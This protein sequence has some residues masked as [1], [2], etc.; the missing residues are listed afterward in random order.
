M[1]I[2][3][4]ADDHVG[5]SM[6]RIMATDSHDV[7][8]PYPDFE[9]LAQ[10]RN[11]RLWMV[12]NLKGLKSKVY[13]RLADK[14]KRCDDISHCGSGMC[15]MCMRRVRLKWVNDGMAH[16]EREWT[17]GHKHVSSFMMV[18]PHHFVEPGKLFTLVPRQLG[19]LMADHMKRAGLH[20][21]HV[22]GGI[23][24]TLWSDRGEYRWGGVIYAIGHHPH[25]MRWPT[26]TFDHQLIKP[27]KLPATLGDLLESFFCFQMP[28][29]DSS[30][31][32]QVPQPGWATRELGLWLDRNPI[33]DRMFLKGVRRGDDGLRTILDSIRASPGTVT[34][35]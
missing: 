14:L 34:S 30:N 23:N 35:H 4:S 24:P 16:I 2:L 29:D 15:P 22:I 13:R 25:D 26:E 28:C 1:K 20:D 12:D 18:V 21:L 7:D 9:T 10:A 27:R 11:C 32:K 17:V 6:E 31:V 3:F 5:I 19:E 33:E 8:Q